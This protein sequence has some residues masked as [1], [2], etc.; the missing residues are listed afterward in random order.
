MCRNCRE[1]PKP[2][3]T[4]RALAITIKQPPAAACAV[5]TTVPSQSPM[6]DESGRLLLRQLLDDEV[7]EVDVKKHLPA[8]AP[9]PDGE[10]K[11][12]P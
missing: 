4:L 1:I 7:M 2:Y 6:D 11:R 9:P 8:H 3:P 5:D 10:P 12:A